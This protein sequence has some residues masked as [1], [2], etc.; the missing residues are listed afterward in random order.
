MDFS[1]GSR[2]LMKFWYD[3]DKY[4][5]SEK[6][7]ENRE[8]TQ[9][10]PSFETL[11]D[12]KDL[13]GV[14]NCLNAKNIYTKLD[15]KHLY[16]I[17]LQAPPGEPG[18]SFI[19]EENVTFLQGN[20]IPI[21]QNL[22]NDLDFIYLDSSHEYNHV[23]TEM[24]IAYPKLKKGGLLAGHDYEQLG[25]MLAYNTL[26]LNVWRATKKQPQNFFIGPCQDNHPGYPEEYL[27]RGFPVDWWH[28]KTDD[29]PDD[30]KIYPLRNG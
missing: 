3:T 9:L 18:I 5:A 10:R 12:K 22:P 7:G 6:W 20:S 2:D 11:K 17:D 14:G 28:L 23:M 27:E 16:L 25:P 19:E 8:L 4:F 26:M 1:Y 24:Q 21:L 29:L 13:V 15:I 30:F